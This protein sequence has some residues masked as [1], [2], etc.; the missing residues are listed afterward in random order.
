MS[1][2]AWIKLALLA[3]GVTV[4]PG[5]DHWFAGTTGFVRRRNFYNSPNWTTTARHVPPQEIQLSGSP[6]VTVAVNDYGPSRW[7]LD[8]D[9]DVGPVIRSDVLPEGH[10]VALLPDLTALRTDPALSRLCNLYGGSALSFFSPRA[11]YFFAEGTQCRFCSLA[12]TARESEEYAGRL[13]PDEI[14]R[15]VLAAATTDRAVINQV[16]IVGGNERHLDR[17]FRHHLVLARAASSALAEAGLREEVSV[18]LVTMPPHDQDLI[19]ELTSIPNLHA[20]FN[21]EVWDPGRFVTTAPGKHADYGRDAIRAALGRLRDAVGAYR[22]HSILIAG[23]E[24]SS[25]TLEGARQLASEGVSPIINAYHSDRHASLGLSVRPTFRQ[26][27]EVAEGLQDLHD[28]YPIQPYWKGCGRNA[29]DAEAAAGLFRGPAPD[30][31]P[32]RG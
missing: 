13:T 19:D 18:H 22:A 12:G 11:C 7:I 1:Q 15:C 32:R 20:G 8:L 25:S 29:L 3:E 6:P 26:L 24:P 9:A 10:P 28:R 17:G 2:A 30:L 4:T 27:A 31:A 14:R 21:L 16:M 23:L 5:F